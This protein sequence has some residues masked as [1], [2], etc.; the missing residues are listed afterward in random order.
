MP[1]RGTQKATSRSSTRFSRKAPRAM[2]P[3]AIPAKEKPKYD[4]SKPMKS[5]VVAEINKKEETHERFYQTVL[6]G[7]PN[8]PSDNAFIFR[9]LPDI[10]QAGQLDGGGDPYPNNRETRTGSNVRLMALN[11]KGRVFIPSSQSPES[12]DRAC[13]SCRFI[14]MSC[15]KLQNWD[16]IYSN[17]DAGHILYN[18]FL[19]N[20]AEEDGFDGYQFGLDLPINHDL[21]TVHVDKKFVLNRGNIEKVNPTGIPAPT[22]GVGAARMPFALKYLN[23]NLKVKSKILKYQNENSDQPTN[24]SPFAVLCWTYTNGAAPSPVRVPSI[25]LNTKARWKNM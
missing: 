3:K 2:Q 11:V 7:L 22:E 19:K 17:W 1:R 25:Q 14:I 16:D 4:L 23:F 13:I 9:L 24:Y 12:D 5:L 20:G 18:K 21:M 15:K 6:Q 8:I 10:Q